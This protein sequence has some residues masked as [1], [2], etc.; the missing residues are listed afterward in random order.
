MMHNQDASTNY[1]F[2]II[3]A[4]I[5]GTIT[6]RELSKYNVKILILEKENDVSMGATKANSAIVHGGYDDKNGSLKSK[7]SYKGRQAFQRYDN[8]LNFGFKKTGSLVVGFDEDKKAIEE[9]YENGL[10]NGV[11]DIRIL[12]KDEIMKMEP[13]I[14]SDIKYALYCEGAGVCSPYEFTIALAENAIKNGV[15]L[16]LNSK[17]TDIKKNS[18]YNYEIKY[19]QRDLSGE[20]SEKE[21]HTS[22]VINAAGMYSDKISDMVNESYF[23]INPRKGEYILFSRGTG[24]LVNTVIFQV[25]SKFGKGVL[26]TSTYHGNLMIGPDAQNDVERTDTSTKMENLEWLLEKARHTTEKFDLKQFIR[27]FSGL[28]AAAST[29]DFIIE[30]TK[31][32]GFVNIAGIQSPGLTSSPAIAEMVID[33]IKDTGFNLDEKLDFDPYRKAIIKR[34]GKDDMLSGIEVNKLVELPSSPEKIICRCEQVTEAVII[35]SLRRGIMVTSVDGVKRRTRSGMG[36][37]QG[38]FCRPRVK[39]IIE[40]EYGIK[41]DDNEDVVHSGM[42]RVGKKEFLEYIKEKE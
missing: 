22:F 12:E 4:G 32:K 6:A 41:I 15:K 14:N 26:V 35:D 40:R 2:V 36:W 9:L 7:V 5:I 16:E 8:E 29:G 27:T 19:K 37:C 11:I 17:V 3:G 10:R 25:P 33:I 20:I 21:V 30:E 39:E 1:D 42:N 13:N 31:E 18:D 38:T 34:K 24:E 28:R 23:T